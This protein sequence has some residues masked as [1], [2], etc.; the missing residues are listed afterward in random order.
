[1]TPASLRRLVAS[2]E[3]LSLEFKRSTGELREG[4]ETLCGF[5]NAEGG[6]VLCGVNR[7]GGIEG[8]QVSEQTLHEITAALQRFEPPA[9]VK[10]ERTNVGQGREVI[11]LAVEPNPGA[12][13]YTFDGRAFLRVGNT[14]RRMRREEYE[15][16]LLDRL[17]ARHRWENLRATGWKVSDLDAGEIR[18][19]VVDA[20]AARRLAAVPSEEPQI[21]LDR[22]GLLVEGVPTQAAVVLFGKR[23]L[24]DYPQCAIRLARFRG[25]TKSEFI[26]NRQF[27]GDAF[28][29]LRR[30]EAFFDTHLPIASRVVP[31]KMRREDRPQYP[32]EALREALIN[33][34]CH[35]DYS[36]AGA[37][38]GVA[39]FD[40]RLEVW[41]YVR[42]G[43]GPST[44]YRLGK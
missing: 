30:A 36:E 10:I 29:L 27:H 37:S 6:R 19:T 16:L 25:V 11:T 42:T 7:K 44:R 26:D 5:L 41:S 43:K 28:E 24:P 9:A 1:M 12:V 21:V 15:R 33:A 35:R 3:G 34:L 14:T 8:Q 13:P 17:H 4:L 2:G 22:L 40:D 32:P 38:I 18:Q 39:I 31:G 23:V 20:V